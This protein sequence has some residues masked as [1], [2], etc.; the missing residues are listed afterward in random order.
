[1]QDDVYSSSSV[2]VYINIYEYIFI[3][4]WF[5]S[6]ILLSDFNFLHNVVNTSLDQVA[7]SVSLCIQS[8]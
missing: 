1:M 8:F 4:G 3:V 5:K 7:W 6:Y 2:G